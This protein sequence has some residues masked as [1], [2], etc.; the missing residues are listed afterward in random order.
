MGTGLYKM[1]IG[2]PYLTVN[3]GGRETV[4]MYNLGCEQGIKHNESDLSI[5][6]T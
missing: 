5:S 6:Q 1:Y 3:Y 2:V 4:I